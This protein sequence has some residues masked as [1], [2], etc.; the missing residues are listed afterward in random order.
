MRFN[1]ILLRFSLFFLASCCGIDV[2]SQ[3]ANSNNFEVISRV[4]F[5]SIPFDAND[6]MNPAIGT[7]TL[8]CT[9]Y[10]DYSLGNTNNGDG[11]TTGAEFFTGVVRN[12][13]Y[14]LEIEGGFCGSTPTV[15]NANRAIKV[16]IDYDASGTFELTE[17]VYT[18]GYYDNNFPIANTTITIPNSASLGPIK[19]RIVYNRVGPFT[20]LWEIPALNWATN[21]YQYGEVEDYSLIVV[22]YMDSVQSTDY[23]CFS[24]SD[25]QIQIFPNIA[26]PTTT[27][28][29]ING[30]AGPW[31]TD[32]IY[33]NVAPGNY[34]IWARDAAMAP[35]YVYEQLQASISAADTFAVLPQI[36]SDFNGS[37]VSCH[38]SSDGEISLTVTGGNP[39]TFTYQYSSLTN[40]TFINAPNPIE[41]LNADT[42]TIVATDPQGCVSLPVEVEILAP[43][44]LIIDLIDV[45]QPITCNSECDAILNIQASGGTLPYTYDVDGNNNG[46]NNIISNV[47]SGNPLVTLEDLNGCS[48]QL[49]GLVTNPSEL[50]LTA[51]V[52]SDYSAFGISCQN[53]SD[54]IVQ[55]N[56]TGGSGGEYIYSINGGLTFPYSSST[57]LDIN[58]LGQGIYTVVAMDSNMCESLPVDLVLNAPP[59]IAFDFITTTSPISCYG[60]NDGVISAQGI[61]GVG[62]YEYSI[63]GGVTVQ[64]SGVFPSLSA[65]DYEI[66]IFDDNN[67]EFSETYSLTQPQE[68]SILSTAITSDYNGS[69]VSCFGASDAVLNID[70]SGG[71]APYGYSLV[72]NPA[73]LPIPMNNLITN[74]SAGTQTIVVFDA[75][76]CESSPQ[77]F[78]VNQPDELIIDLIDVVQSITCNSECD[79]IL[80]IQASGGTLPYTYD[81]DGNNNGNNN[82]ISNVCSGNPLVT[83]E[84]LNGCSVQLNGLVTNPSEL[85]LTASV[86]SDYSA[87][88]ISCQNAS[89]GIVQVNTTGG[90]GGEY[91]YSI[92]GGLTFPYSSSTTLDINSLG[93]GIYTVVAMDSNMC[94]S[95]PVDL[96]LNAPPAIAFDFITTTSPISCYGFNDGVI[97]AQGINGVGGYEYSIDGGVTVQAS[98]VFPSLSAGDYEITIFDDNNCEFSETYSLTQPQE[99][100]ILSTAITSDYNGSEVSCFGASDAVLNIDVSGGTAPYGYSLVSNP[101]ILPIPMNNLITNLSA[102]T[103]TIV[104][105]DANNCES[106]PQAFEVNQP[107]ELIISSIN[108]VSNVSCFG[109]SDGEITINASG[110]TGSYSY[111]VD[112]LYNSADQAPFQVN[113]LAANV[114]NIVVTDAN[115]CSSPSSQLEIT[116]PNQIEANLSYINLGCDGDFGSA[117]VSPV[118]GSPSYIVSWSNGTTGTSINQ[119]T[120]GEYSVTITD[121]LNCQELIDFQITEP[122]I[123]T[124]IDPILCNGS[125]NG[126]ITATIN[127]PNPASIFSIL[128]DDDN[129]QTTSTAT[130][131]SAG[132]YTVTM[133][134]QFGCVLTASTIL[135]EPDS[136]NVFVEHTQLCPN[137]PIATALV[138]ASGGLIP[139]DYL[140]S[141]NE[142]SE[143]IYIQN[144][145]IYSIQ[146]TDY[147]NCQQ[148]VEISIDPINPVQLDFVSQAVSCIDNNDGSVELFPTGGYEPYTYNWSNYTEEALNHEL[149]SGLYGVT[150]MDNNGCEYYQE[151]EVPSSDQRCITAYSAFSP[152]GDQNNDYWHIA[153]IELYPDALVEVFNRWGDRVYSTKKYMNSWDGAWQGM[154]ENN[155]LPSATYYYVITLNNDEEPI[156]GTVTVVR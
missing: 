152:N 112:Q 3:G 154:Y 113:G 137:N 111:F 145:G 103:Q 81:V 118:G 68:I 2:F 33:N 58:S 88:G 76:N 16:Y 94:E 99:I 39:S 60:F 70:V 42:Y 78:E 107:D 21:N 32:L 61:N 40:P 24:S 135:T 124:T 62:G 120:P 149:Q 151:V 136:L 115:L 93:Q 110:G 27:E 64:A 45:V 134:D 4:Y 71:T 123:T 72:S 117:M 6:I 108:P 92:N 104:V 1:Q 119:L 142:T 150:V 66:T 56:T 114:Y 109:G 57:T 9:G 105:F 37:N 131:L 139:Y 31:S 86:I 7:N 54:G 138:F 85:S 156:V 5:G 55:V 38:N 102:G 48:V 20:A 12:G 8:P 80:N 50:S 34:D 43:Q 69:E 18:S 13:T 65:G 126:E 63:D 49:N 83:L 122:I 47:C 36:I 127:N 96:V 106:S 121:Q 100:S 14:N 144:P 95:L 146:V 141:T 22:G 132:D 15:F 140:W 46:N 148:D 19:M 90:S 84:D 41:G 51:S 67:C 74:L 153:N 125:G 25:G 52:I 75:N 155:P 44:E 53:A 129:N 116:H 77:A 23:T 11:N 87:F 82:I 147:N 30:L 26:A 133:T 91:I 101:A 73:I 35:N 130:G 28:F 143:L 79:A 29:S 89:D 59:A 98:G 17:L 10:S 97:S 128:W